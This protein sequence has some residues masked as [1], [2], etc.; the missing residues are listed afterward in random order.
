MGKEKERKTGAKTGG[1]IDD[2]NHSY[3]DYEDD[4]GEEYDDDDDDDDGEEDGRCPVC[5]PLLTS[6]ASNSLLYIPLRAARL[7]V[8]LA[9]HFADYGVDEALAVPLIVTI[10]QG[11]YDLTVNHVRTT[12][13][14]TPPSPSSPQPPLSTR[15]PSSPPLSS[16]SPSSTPPSQATTVLKGSDGSDGPDGS[17][18]SDWSESLLQLRL[19]ASFPL[20]YGDTLCGMC[21]CDVVQVSVIQVPLIV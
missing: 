11:Q 14:P 19:Q 9:L 2:D 12:S 15:S 21:P 20:P 13:S 4:D 1:N 7:F 5:V 8:R 16:P 10:L 18:W 6:H 3:K 17:D